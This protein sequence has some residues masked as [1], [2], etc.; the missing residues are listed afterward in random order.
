MWKKVG[1]GVGSRGCGG[2]GKEE[3]WKTRR[4]EKLKYPGLVR[5]EKVRKKGNPRSLVKVKKR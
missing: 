3:K 2:N 4:E 5:G 1:S